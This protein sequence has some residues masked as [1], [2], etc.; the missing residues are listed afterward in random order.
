METLGN[1]SAGTEL[2]LRAERRGGGAGRA[3]L[4]DAW[5]DKQPG[6]GSRAPSAPAPLSCRGPGLPRCRAGGKA[7]H[8][9]SWRFNH[10]GYM[11][12]SANRVEGTG[13][14]RSSAGR[15]PL[16]W[17]NNDKH[18][19][20]LPSA[21]IFTT[22]FWLLLRSWGSGGLRVPARRSRGRPEALGAAARGPLSLGSARWSLRESVHEPARSKRSVYASPGG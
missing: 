16:L 15:R 8:G 4:G 22:L 19:R 5:A 11:E 18:N 1:R 9:L 20:E 2:P 12:N 3:Q 13:P 21:V 10:S 7:E 14:V 17:K 6:A